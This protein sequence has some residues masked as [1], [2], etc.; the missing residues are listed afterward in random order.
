[1]NIVDGT[2][3]ITTSEHDTSVKVSYGEPLGIKLHKTVVVTGEATNRE[4]GLSQ[5]RS[6]KDVVKVKWSWKNRSTY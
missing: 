5:M 1:V 6:N 4:K 3:A 2:R